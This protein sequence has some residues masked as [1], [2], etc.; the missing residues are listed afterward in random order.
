MHRDGRGAFVAGVFWSH[1]RVA[2]REE[3]DNSAISAH[4]TVSAVHPKMNNL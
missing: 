4:K 1:K 3:R 2:A